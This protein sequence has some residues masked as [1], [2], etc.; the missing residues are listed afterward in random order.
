MDEASAIEPFVSDFVG[1]A[2][3]KVVHVFLSINHCIAKFSLVEDLSV[4]WIFS[5][6][7]GSLEFLPTLVKVLLAA[8]DE[9]KL[10]WSFHLSCRILHF[11]SQFQVLFNENLHLVFIFTQIFSPNSP[12]IADGQRLTTKIGHLHRMLESI[13]KPINT[14]GI[15]SKS[16]IAETHIDGSQKFPINISKLLM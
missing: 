6:L 14:I 11:L 9:A 7:Q 2:G 15:I 16:I 8:V 13:L 1:I 4:S 12:D 3:Q 10:D 5:Q